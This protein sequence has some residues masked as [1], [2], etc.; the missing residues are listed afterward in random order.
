MSRYDLKLANH[1]FAQTQDKTISKTNIDDCVNA[2]NKEIGFDCQSFDYCYTSGN[3]HLS[4]TD[5]G[6]D[7]EEYYYKTNECDIYESNWIKWSNK[8]EFNK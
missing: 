6:S 2:C 5:I 3:C 1:R 7:I 8:R 4:R